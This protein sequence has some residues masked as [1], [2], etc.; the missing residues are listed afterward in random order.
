MQMGYHSFKR[1]DLVV[2]DGERD[3]GD[4][5]MCEIMY[6]CM[7]FTHRGQ[8]RRLLI[9]YQSDLN[10]FS[11]NPWTSWKRVLEDTAGAM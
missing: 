4:D 3:E 1:G 5:H 2:W 10:Q 7:V 11:I 8:Q 6:A 9:T